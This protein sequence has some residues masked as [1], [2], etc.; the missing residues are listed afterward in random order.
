MLAPSPCLLLR[1]VY[2]QFPAVSC[3][4]S[5]RSQPT[6]PYIVLLGF[7]NANL[8]A[9]LSC[10][11]MF[12]QRVTTS[13]SAREGPASSVFIKAIVVKKAS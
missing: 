12:A 10:S 11:Q 9:Q 7:P 5:A 2:P 13:V 6:V 8:K 1:A 3:R 4:E